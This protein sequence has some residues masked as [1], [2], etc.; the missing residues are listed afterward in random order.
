MVSSGVRIGVAAMTS[1]GMGPKEMD[2]I[3]DFM[4]RVADGIDDEIELDSI[5]KEVVDFA[6]QFPLYDGYFQ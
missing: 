4:A 2:I 5:S 1:K 6:K 3:A